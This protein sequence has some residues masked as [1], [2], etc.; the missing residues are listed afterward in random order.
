MAEATLNDVVTN[1][2]ADNK[3]L[4]SIEQNTLDTKKALN[5][6]LATQQ[7][8]AGDQLEAMRELGGGRQGAEAKRQPLMQVVVETYSDLLAA[9]G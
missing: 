6:F 9:W 5:K 8:M 2:K 7:A 3:R 1:L 4:T